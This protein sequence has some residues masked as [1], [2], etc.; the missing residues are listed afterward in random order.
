MTA[1]TA[2]RTANTEVTLV[3][4][5][6]SLGGIETLIVRLCNQLTA[7]GRS[8]R[9]LCTGGTLMTDLPPAA[10]VLIYSGW[11]EALEKFNS[12]GRPAQGTTHLVV[13]F[14][15]TTA[16]L[17]SWLIGQSPRS[18]AL[19]H[20]TGI[21]HPRAYFLDG[22]DR[23]RRAIN[24]MILRNFRDDQVFFMNVE[25]RE[26]H[27]EWA[28]RDFSDCPIIPLGITERQP[29]YAPGSRQTFK[30]VSVGRLVRFKDFNLEIPAIVSNLRSRAIEISWKIFGCGE[31]EQEIRSRIAEFGVDQF[32]TLGGE[33]PYAELSTELV[34]HDAFVG[35]GSTVLEAGMVG[36][37]SIM[38]IDSEGARTYGFVQDV[39]FGNVGERQSEPPTKQISELL[40]ELHSKSTAERIAIGTASRNAVLG[41]SMSAYSAGLVRI[42]VES[43]PP[44]KWRSRLLGTLY[45]QA[46]DGRS[47]RSI[48]RL[49]RPFRKTIA[50]LFRSTPA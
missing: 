47:R 10:E 37:P 1:V 15:P 42:G 48:N 35:T 44:Q 3:C 21:F 25:T 45:H 14:D 46:T 50:A 40:F 12:I 31:L 49:A 34:R 20:I 33:L 2:P 29:S 36:M 43:S 22:E 28:A 17:A 41:Y 4:G 30:V 23:L 16:A 13:S 26:S 11:T 24:R 18:T 8:V 5:A 39:P 19:R 27:T 32:V 38:A 7:E 9:L 6:L